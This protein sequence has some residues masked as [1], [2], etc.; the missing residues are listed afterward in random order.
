MAVEVASLKAVL[1]LDK[2]D[3][4]TG[5]KD[6]QKELTGF[7]KSISG[8]MATLGTIGV[9]V[10][11]LSG[12]TAVIAGW[13]NAA[14]EAAAI[15]R[16]LEQT[17]KSTGGVAGVTA[18]AARD[19]ADSLSRV[20]NFEDD[21][22]V[23][24][25]AML[26]TFTKIGA[27]VFPQATETMLDMAQKMGSDLP[28]AA[29]QLGKAL[30][31]PLKGIS[32]LQR[33]GVTFSATQ[34]QQIKDFMAVNDIASAQRVILSE[35]A[36]EFGGQARAA[37]DPMIQ[38]QNAIGNAG[39]ALGTYFLPILNQIVTSAMPGF[40]DMIKV[41]GEVLPQMGAMMAEAIGPVFEFLG[42]A[43][44][45]VA[46]A[47]GQLIEGIKSLGAALG[48]DTEGVTALRVALILVEIPLTIIGGILKALALVLNVVG[49]SFQA[50]GY[51]VERVAAGWG[52]M[53][54]EGTRLGAVGNSLVGVWNGI[55]AALGT[56][57]QWV[58]NIIEGWRL[59]IAVLSQP[60]NLPKDITPGSPTPLENGIRGISAAIGAMP[61]LDLN[62]KI[63]PIQ[64]APTTTSVTN[65]N[66][67]GQS[68]SF[69]GNN[70]NE[71]ALVTLVRVLRNQLAATG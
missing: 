64:Q 3:F 59:L 32:A 6:S 7:S 67:G 61:Q 56:L 71:Q 38:L 66:M 28:G 50:M 27:D 41:L 39:E 24:G 9:A 42:S 60:I 19:L 8:A 62:S 1:G 21:T 37:A 46:A 30:N 45:D 22:I 49:A 53:T 2:K 17:I 15:N 51:V 63:V 68:F 12:V 26:L 10:G 23:K 20:T 18:D 47:F 44:V 34:K 33:V 5:L 57:W 31:D 13:T 29:I 16:D 65:L 4:D 69:Q 48:F 36:T 54:G 35:L 58:L 40:L 55:S 52:R 25:E 43:I 11:A 14:R 70:A